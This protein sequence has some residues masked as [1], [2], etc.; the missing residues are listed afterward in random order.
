MGTT[1]AFF[2]FSP[3]L[4]DRE[5]EVHEAR[6]IIQ[7]GKD[8]VNVH[9]I[10]YSSVVMTGKHHTFLTTYKRNN[11]MTAFNP[12]DVEK[13][14][15]AAITQPETYSHYEIDLGVESLTP[16]EISRE[17]SRASGKGINVELYSEE[18]M[19]GFS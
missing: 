10:V 5:S 15:A 1:A 7:D 16:G 3:S 4:T 18:E 11:A 2:D 19:P 9:K 17:L 14:A 6:N 13:F 12:S 8:A